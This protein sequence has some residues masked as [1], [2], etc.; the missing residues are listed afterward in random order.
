[1]TKSPPACASL[2]HEGLDARLRFKHPEQSR[3]YR[4][5]RH[6]IAF[7]SRDRVSDDADFGREL[8]L[9]QSESLP[10]V[11]EFATVHA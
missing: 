1:V 4:A 10:N 8:R 5:N 7:P 9:R 3:C 11:F 2:F 6:F